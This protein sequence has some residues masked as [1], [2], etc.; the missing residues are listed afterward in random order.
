M[1]AGQLKTLRQKF[2][3]LVVYSEIL[4]CYFEMRKYEIAPYIE[5]FL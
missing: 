5:A 3:I 1:K 4:I 2:R